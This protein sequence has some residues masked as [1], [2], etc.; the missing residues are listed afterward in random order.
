MNKN[1]INNCKWCTDNKGRTLMNFLVLDVEV[2]KYVPIKRIKYCP[3]CGRKL[4]DEG[5]IK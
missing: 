1:K 3:F 5:D 2:M 4:K